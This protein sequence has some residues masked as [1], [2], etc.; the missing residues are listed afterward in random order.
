MSNVHEEFW[1]A[2]KSE[3]NSRLA[4]RDFSLSEAGDARSQRQKVGRVEFVPERLVP[5]S[6]GPGWRTR[7]GHLVKNQAF[8]RLGTGQAK[9][10]WDDEVHCGTRTWRY[11]HGPRLR[12]DAPLL[13]KLDAQDDRAERR[14]LEIDNVNARRRENLARTRM[15]RDQ[16]AEFARSSSW[17]PCER[18]RS[19]HVDY[20][21]GNAISEYNDFNHQPTKALQQVFTKSVLDKD[22]NAISFISENMQKEEEFK[23]HYAAWKEYRR[24]DTLQAL[25]HQRRYNDCL[26]TMA[27]QPPRCRALRYTKTPLSQRMEHLSQP[28]K[29]YV[30]PDITRRSDFRGLV[31][32]DFPM[33][34]EKLFPHPTTGHGEEPRWHADRTVSP[35]APATY[36]SR[37]DLVLTSPR[38]QN[39]PTQAPAAPHIADMN[40]LPKPHTKDVDPKRYKYRVETPPPTQ[41]YTYSVD[42]PAAD[43]TRSVSAAKWD[44]Q[45]TFMPSQSAPS[46]LGDV[47]ITENG[48]GSPK[49]KPTTAVLGK[50]NSCATLLGPR[51]PVALEI[52]PNAYV[53][54]K[55]RL[56]VG[57]GMTHELQHK[58]RSRTSASHIG[59]S[60]EKAATRDLALDPTGARPLAKGGPLRYVQDQ[61][62][63]GRRRAASVPAGSCS[64]SGDH[65]YPFSDESHA[66]ADRQ[67]RLD[68]ARQPET[69]AQP[70]H[71]RHC[72]GQEPM[73]EMISAGP[74]GGYPTPTTSWGPKDRRTARCQMGYSDARTGFSHPNKTTSDLCAELDAFE[75]FAQN[76]TTKTL[77][78]H[79]G[80]FGLA[81]AKSSVLRRPV[82]TPSRSMRPPSEESS[83]SRSG[84]AEARF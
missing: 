58:T 18:R 71:G 9:N 48:Q 5:D 76:T 23:A 52:A 43:I 46:L 63:D 26:E 50:S 66:R 83:P 51:A 20:G 25:A 73:A 79:L 81:P 22:K 45:N 1:H 3:W 2:S 28:K 15:K 78:N 47:K 56:R 49:T 54:A 33:A 40:P 19:E 41:T 44:A 57:R 34:L 12:T 72:V 6:R 59:F 10:V 82:V 67:A 53:A 16:N 32:A 7:H 36:I 55:Q 14:Q 31:Y 11:W 77:D 65:V 4:S 62:E 37:S 75:D 13:E 68:A 61:S 42:V 74:A 35:E 17:A 30:L 27:G 39:Q 64:L 60:Q 29:E 21:A 24:R 70:S 69:A 80:N 8:Y 38:T 84:F